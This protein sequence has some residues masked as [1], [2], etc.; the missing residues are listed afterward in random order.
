M[1]MAHLGRMAG[2][3]QALMRQPWFRVTAQFGIIAGCLAYLLSNLNG[4]LGFIR[5]LRLGYVWLVSALAFSTVDV[6][7]GAAAWCLILRGL[8]Q[9]VSWLDAARTHIYSN[10][11]KYLPGY[12]WQLVG[13][14][15]ATN[16]L[17]VGAKVVG[18]G[19]VFELADL[20]MVGFGMALATGPE[21]FLQ[22]W[23]IHKNL[24]V[25]VR[26]VGLMLI[27][28][29]FVV[30]TLF[31]SFMERRAAV[32]RIVKRP[33]LLAIILTLGGW[34][35]LGWTFWLVGMSVR[36]LSVVTIPLFMSTL[37]VSFL[38]GLFVIFVPGG[39]GVR[40]SIMVL[41]LTPVVSA[42]G[43]VVVAGLSRVVFVLS[44]FVAAAL[45]R[46]M[47]SLK[48]RVSAVSKTVE[49]GR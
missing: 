14:A 25:G 34:A 7:V 45:L 9:P 13:K 37:A 19:M 30:V 10:L 6:F 8:C 28:A 39:I 29:A 35:M 23:A 48:S 20:T 38:I 5:G 11:G 24:L 44:D 46:G 42:P 12:A 31:S 43:A 47:L 40:E 2:S 21:A 22:R 41:L 26:I 16:Q 27:G 32:A 36:H 17:G 3:I 15:Y 49:G 1:L 4:W 33:L 18:T